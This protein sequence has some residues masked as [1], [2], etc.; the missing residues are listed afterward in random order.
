MSDAALDYRHRIPH[1]ARP[2]TAV[3]ASLIRW[4]LR[5]VTVVLFGAA[6]ALGVS[7]GLSAPESSPASV[8]D[9]H[10]APNQ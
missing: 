9:H 5:T 3:S 8:V 10:V 7:L 1:I 4:S 6:T 2:A